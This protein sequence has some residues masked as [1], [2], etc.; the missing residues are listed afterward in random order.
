MLLELHI[1]QCPMAARRNRDDTP[2]L[3]TVATI[4]ASAGN[5]LFSPEADAT[6]SAVPGFNIYL[7]FVNESHCKSNRS[8]PEN[9]NAGIFG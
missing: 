8:P 3:T 4:G 9:E 6:L 1:Q 5:K 2:P 7:C